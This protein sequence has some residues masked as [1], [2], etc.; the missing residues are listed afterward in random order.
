MQLHLAPGA[1]PAAVAR[2]WQEVLGTA[3]VVVSRRTAVEAGLFGPVAA[4][5]EPM[6]G[7]LV[8]AMAG[9]ATVVDSRSQTPASIGLLGVH[10]SLT[11]HEVA[12]PLLVTTR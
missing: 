11:K 9:R 12:V 4:R 7:D 8:V 6:I 10:G 5:V 2:R 1:D 3:A